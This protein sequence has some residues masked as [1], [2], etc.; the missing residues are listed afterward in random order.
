M[1]VTYINPLRTKFFGGNSNIYLHF[2]SFLQID[3]TQVLK[4]RPQGRPGPTYSA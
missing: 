1:H 3:L 4:I 2:K